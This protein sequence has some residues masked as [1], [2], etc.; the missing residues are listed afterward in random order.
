[1]EV[2]VSSVLPTTLPYLDDLLYGVAAG[3]RREFPDISPDRVASAVETARA[4][5]LDLLPDLSAYAAAVADWARQD[6]A[7]RSP[8]SARRMTDV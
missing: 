1:M 8:N 5:A 2:L 3:L 6:L 4:P 7:S